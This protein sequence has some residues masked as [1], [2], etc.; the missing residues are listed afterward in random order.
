ML[1]SGAR[2]CDSWLTWNCRALGLAGSCGGWGVSGVRRHSWWLSPPG[3]AV[4]CV[5]WQTLSLGWCRA[6]GGAERVAEGLLS[7]PR[8]LEQPPQEGAL[9]PTGWL[10]PLASPVLYWI[11][12]PWLCSDGPDLLTCSHTSESD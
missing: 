4:S 9:A 12:G 5:A 7:L 11:S 10:Y 1:T 8:P 3:G 2:C 6:L